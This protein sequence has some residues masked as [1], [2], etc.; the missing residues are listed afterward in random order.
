[1]NQA[2]TDIL[3]H[4]YDPERFREQGHALVDLLAD[5]LANAQQG[6]YTQALPYQT[7]E[8]ML[9]Q[10]QETL[11]KPD[12]VPAFVE[13]LLAHTIRLHH[14]HY[15]GHQVT[16]ALPLAAL[17]DF[18]GR[19]LN[20]GVAVYEMGS[21]AVVMER[22]VTQHLAQ[23]LGWD[24]QS[25]GF[26]TSGGSL[27][28]FT[29]LLGATKI[30]CEALGIALHQAAWMVSEE[31]HYSVARAFRAMGLA[32]SQ[33]VHLPVNKQYQIDPERLA[34]TYAQAQAAGLHVVG[35]VGNA[36]TTATGTFDDLQAL[37]AF[38]QTAGLWFH[39][40]AAHGGGAIFSPQYKTLLAGIELADSV[41]V[42][43]HKM[44]MMPSLVTA[45]MFRRGHESYR[46]FAQKADYLWAQ[47][48]QEWFTLGK[49]TLE[50]T[51]SSMGVKIFLTLQQYDTRVFDAYVTSRF[52]LARRFATILEAQPDFEL[53]LTPM[54][55]IVCFRYRQEG[56][57][58]T[59]TDTLNEAIH[60]ALVQEGSFFIVRT[61]LRGRVYLRTTLMSPFTEEVHL[62]TL[63][64][65][66]QQLAQRHLTLA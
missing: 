13:Q 40:D 33:L 23:H 19:T 8:A 50:C 42:D 37:A 35:L 12:S 52:D 31:S 1:M 29:A 28:N 30:R 24:T 61:K 63:L 56:L 5:H 41:I 27:G 21:P 36:C 47:E 11:T 20:A 54:S 53:F 66:L 10:W 43:Y 34:Q 48:D 59:Q 51:K 3:R 57:D 14:P 58:D 9:V 17:S 46:T 32:D 16:A 26:L 39:V 65:H 15:M 45:V 49:R 18:V 4:A 2:L 62:H 44:L 6:H 60:T 7:P 25:E 38:A 22:I 64:Q 55:N